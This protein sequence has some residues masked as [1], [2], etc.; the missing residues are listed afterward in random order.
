LPSNQTVLFGLGEIKDLGSLEMIHTKIKCAS[1]GARPQFKHTIKE[2]P[3]FQLLLSIIFTLTLILPINAGAQETATIVKVI[4][5]D[6]LKVYYQKHEENTRLIGID[7]PESSA[8][9]KAEK[10]AKRSGQ[11]IKT[12]TAMGKKATNYVKSILKPGDT[13]SLEFDVKHRDKYGRLLHYVYLPDGKML[14]EEIVKA[15]Y[16]QVMTYPPNIKYQERFLKAYRK[17]RESKKGLWNNVETQNLASL[18]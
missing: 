17:A 7:T 9:R 6:T 8:N 4:D 10:D 18:Q 15:G 3:V 14:N 2:V 16:A 12:L 11:D 13:V 5:G 1:S